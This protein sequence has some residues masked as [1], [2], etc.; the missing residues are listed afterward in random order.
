SDR[1]ALAVPAAVFAAAG[2]DE[3]RF[4]VLGKRPASLLRL[5]ASVDDARAEA[6]VSVDGLYIEEVF[7][8]VGGGGDGSQ[9]V[10]VVN[11]TAVTIDLAD[12]LLGSARAGYGETVLALTGLLQPRECSVVGGPDSNADN[13]DP[14]YDQ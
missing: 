7:Y 4:D 6:T 1:T 8:G 3:V 10:R 12:Y 14:V 5:S 9:W 2:Q 13:G 11:A